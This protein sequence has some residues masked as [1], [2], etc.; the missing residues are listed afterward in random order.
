M[1]EKYRDV[2][3]DGS[4]ANLSCISELFTKKKESGRNNDGNNEDS[5]GGRAG[6][7]NEER[8]SAFA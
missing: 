2:P 1:R 8:V 6:G 5:G 3:Q 4:A 7:G